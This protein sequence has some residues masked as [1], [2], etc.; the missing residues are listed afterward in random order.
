MRDSAYR[1]PLPGLLG[2]FSSVL[3]DCR[4]NGRS[5]YNGWALFHQSPSRKMPLDT[6]LWRHFHNGGPLLSED[7]PGLVSNGQNN[8][9]HRLPPPEVTFALPAEVTYG[10]SSPE[11][12]YEFHLR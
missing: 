5:T 11:L 9:P 1:F 10:L 6:V 2:L 4:P 3:E 8:E 12:T 7:K